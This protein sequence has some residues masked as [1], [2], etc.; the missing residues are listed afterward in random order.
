MHHFLTN[1]LSLVFTSLY[2]SNLLFFFLLSFLCEDENEFWQVTGSG[3]NIFAA[4]RE[5]SSWKEIDLSV[6][7]SL[8]WLSLPCTLVITEMRRKE[9]TTNS[10]KTQM[11][12]RIQTSLQNTPTQQG[13]ICNVNRAAEVLKKQFILHKKISVQFSSCIRDLYRSTLHTI[14]PAVL[15]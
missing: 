7:R 1:T 3:F 12:L 4:P 2:C 15:L 10:L 13:T 8:L 11:S 14:F 6:S 9:K 5:F